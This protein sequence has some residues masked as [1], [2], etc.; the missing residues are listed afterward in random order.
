MEG[1]RRAER[2]DNIPWRTARVGL[3]RMLLIVVVTVNLEGWKRA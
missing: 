3:A 1:S 2:G